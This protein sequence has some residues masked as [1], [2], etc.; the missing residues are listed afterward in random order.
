MGNVWRLERPALWQLYRN[1]ADAMAN[2][3]Q[4][5]G[6]HGDLVHPVITHH[7]RLDSKVNEVMLWHG[8]EVE[9]TDIIKNRACDNDEVKGAV[10]NVYSGGCFFT[11]APCKAGQYA[12][13]GKG[14]ARYLLYCRV[15]LGVPY[16]ATG[17][18][19]SSTPCVMQ[20]QNQ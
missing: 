16:H 7:D 2:Q 19:T 8:A 10:D 3:G 4:D 15:L 5:G 12:P 17:T 20:R 1:R 6:V 18:A 14:G 13:E 11:S 9:V